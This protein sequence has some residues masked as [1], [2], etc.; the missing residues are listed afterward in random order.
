MPVLHLVIPFLNEESTLHTI[1]D[2]LQACHWPEGWTASVVLV[3]DGSDEEAARASEDLAEARGLLDLRLI[4]HDV[5]RGKGAALRTGFASVI[6]TASDDDLVGVQ[7]ADLEYDPADLSRM[8][9][10]I[11]EAAPRV[12]GAFGN[13]WSGERDTAI[14]RIHRLGNQTLTRISNLFTGFSISD[15][16][17]CYKVMRVPMLKKVL[18][19]L[20]ENRFAIEPQITAALARHGALLIETPVSYEPRSFSDGKKI[21]FRDGVAAVNAMIREWRR[22]RRHRKDS[23]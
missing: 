11:I 10:E 5:N 1:V 23:A 21:G 15:M 17:C 3:D 9:T 7:D 14:R 4:R 20:D 19:D 2:R 16:E 22:T 13:R 12:D 18:P 6:R 8:I